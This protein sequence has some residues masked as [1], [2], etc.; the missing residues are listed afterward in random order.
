MPNLT[1]EIEE[2]YK[3]V[4]AEMFKL[5][6]KLPKGSFR[7][8]AEKYGVKEYTLRMKYWRKLNQEPSPF[9]TRKAIVKSDSP[10]LTLENE[11]NNVNKQTQSA[12]DGPKRLDNFDSRSF[13][14][15]YTVRLTEQNLECLGKIIAKE[16]WKQMPASIPMLIE[17][18]HK[19][20]KPSIDIHVPQKEKLALTPAE[21]SEL[22]GM[23]VNS[24]YKL[25]HNG[26][27]PSVK[28][29]MERKFL[30][31]RG[32]LIKILAGGV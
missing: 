15:V 28:L 23:S 11:F 12:A 31:S 3:M 29:G 17:K 9:T 2:R 16:I 5:G 14:Q 1:P 32:E 7:I 21:A 10:N 25:I 26:K 4:I 22:L 8:F 27:I 20:E 13:K 24:V 19:T 18:L 6:R 30:I